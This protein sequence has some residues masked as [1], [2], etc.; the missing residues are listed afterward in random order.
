MGFQLIVVSVTREGQTRTV[1]VTTTGNVKPVVVFIVRCGPQ[2]V[3]QMN[4]SRPFRV[5]RI[6]TGF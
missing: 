5:A 3:L 2:K 1:E 6:R 4:M